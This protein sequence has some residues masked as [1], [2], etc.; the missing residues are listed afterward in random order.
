MSVVVLGLSNICGR[1][2]LAQIAA[3]FYDLGHILR[4]LFRVKMERGR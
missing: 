3:S 4:L 2:W 1:G